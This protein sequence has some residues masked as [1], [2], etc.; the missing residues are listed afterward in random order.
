MC[1]AGVSQVDQKAGCAGVSFVFLSQCQASDHVTYSQYLMSLD[2]SCI[3]KF[4]VLYI[5]TFSLKR[6]T[7]HVDALQTA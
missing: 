3:A 4:A 2:P 1:D 5:N 6:F 7:P